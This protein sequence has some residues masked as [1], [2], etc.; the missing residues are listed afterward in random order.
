MSRGVSRGWR[1]EARQEERC[2]RRCTRETDRE[3]RESERHVVPERA[4]RERER[5]ALGSATLRGC[6]ITIYSAGS[7][8][9]ERE[10]ECGEWRVSEW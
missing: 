3:P 6:A 10:S 1:G 2:T 5:Q 9:G 7:R 8:A 4:T